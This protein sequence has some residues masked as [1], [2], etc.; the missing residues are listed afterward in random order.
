[1]ERLSVAVDPDLLEKAMRM[2]RAKTKRA[3][4]EAALREFVRNRARERLLLMAGAD[5]VTWTEE[6]L[7]RW[8]A[9]EG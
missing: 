5:L 8:R 1:M 4:I 7:A 6:E 9:N 2:G 3:V